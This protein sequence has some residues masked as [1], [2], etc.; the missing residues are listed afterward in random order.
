MLTK[1]KDVR[2]LLRQAE[3]AGWEFWP[4]TNGH[5]RGRHPDSPV[6]TTLSCKVSDPRSLMNMKK[7]L[8][9]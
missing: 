2:K 3:R 1:D 5:I 6:T 7:Q 4:A 8:G 9:L